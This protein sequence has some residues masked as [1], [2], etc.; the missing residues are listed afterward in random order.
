MTNARARQRP[1]MFL[2]VEV[3]TGRRKKDG[4][5]VGM[6]S[7]QVAHCLTFVPI[8][9]VPQQQDGLVGIAAQQVA[10]KV[11]RLDAGQRWSRQ[12]ELMPSA[13]VERAVEMHMVTLPTDAHDR[14]LPAWCP[15]A[16]RGRLQI[17]AH[18]VQ[19]KNLSVRMVLQKVGHFFQAPSQTPPALPYSAC[20][21]RP[22]SCAETSVRWRAAGRDNYPRPCTP[23]HTTAPLPP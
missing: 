15:Q 13:Q 23:P 7:Q 8:G 17:Q 5:D 11:R 21:D 18:F 1:D 4:L 14:R 12:S 10:H 2:R 16:G 20:G 9:A 6:S 19:P 3:G 22:W